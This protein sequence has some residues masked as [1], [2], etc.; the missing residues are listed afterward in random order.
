MA[1]A[2]VGAVRFADAGWK[3]EGD[4]DRVVVV[5]KSFGCWE[6]MGFRFEL[7][8]VGEVGVGNGFG[9]GLGVAGGLEMVYGC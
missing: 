3:G 5:V 9:G 1:G 6:R 8:G 4:T 2:L 7:A